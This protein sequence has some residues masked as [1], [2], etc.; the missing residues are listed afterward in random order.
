L[1]RIL[2][3]KGGVRVEHQKRTLEQGGAAGKRRAQSGG[4]KKHI[5][6]GMLT[7]RGGRMDQL[8]EGNDRR[9]G[10]PVRAE[11]S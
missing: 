7:R 9:M 3:G 8:R 4:P 2:L 1:D 5:G 6:D 10:V 11:H